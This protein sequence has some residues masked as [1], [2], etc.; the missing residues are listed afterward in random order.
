LDE[1][2]WISSNEE[3][4]GANPKKNIVA[5]LVLALFDDFHVQL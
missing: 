2:A 5:N 3:G 1:E 4:Y